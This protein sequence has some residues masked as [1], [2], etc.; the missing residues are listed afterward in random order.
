MHAYVLL[1]FVLLAGK[2]VDFDNELKLQVADGDLRTRLR[3]Q[4]PSNI[5]IQLLAGPREIRN[6]I[7]GA[8]LRVIAVVSFIVGPIALLLLFQLQFLPY[9]D[10][11]ITWWHRIAVLIDISLIWM[12]W[13]RISRGKRT[14]PILR[15]IRWSTREVAVAAAL[16]ALPI[17]FVC[18]IATAPGDS[19]PLR[20]STPTVIKGPQITDS[21][22]RP[23]S[24]RSRPEITELLSRHRPSKRTA[25][26]PP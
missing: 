12:F 18:A 14:T 5:F 21:R 2:I 19:R 25:N 23:R 8:A 24:F 16:S 7:V 22:I 4:L 13:P 9:H 1:N 6:G 15:A 11:A 3:R 20:F 17:L 10:A 26:A